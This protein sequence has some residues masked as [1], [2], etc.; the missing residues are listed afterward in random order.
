[1]EAPPTDDG[2]RPC[3]KVDPTENGESTVSVGDCGERKRL[4]YYTNAAILD[5]RLPRSHTFTAAERI[6]DLNLDGRINLG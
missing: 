3:R 6:L 5:P 1:M 4:S 2:A